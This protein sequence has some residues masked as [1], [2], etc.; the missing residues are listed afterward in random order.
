MEFEP[1]PALTRD[2]GY[3]GIE[4]VAILEEALNLYFLIVTIKK[5]KFWL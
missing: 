2:V 1:I 4:I 5:E 3:S